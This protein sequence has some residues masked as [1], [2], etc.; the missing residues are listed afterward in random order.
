MRLHLI[1]TNIPIRTPLPDELPID[2]SPGGWVWKTQE[3]M[4]FG[5]HGEETRFPQIKSY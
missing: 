1:E 4:L 5:R 3:P 2:E